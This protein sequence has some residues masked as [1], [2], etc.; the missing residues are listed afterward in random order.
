MKLSAA[1]QLAMLAA[2]GVAVTIGG[3]SVHADGSPIMGEFSDPGKPVFRNGETI[4]TDSPALLLSEADA[5][6]VT[7]DETVIV[8]DGVNYQAYE[9]TP[10]GAGFVE[11]D[12]T[13]DY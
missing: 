9:K 7:K 3:A 1:E 13:R 6:L 12:L 2:L 4:I 10:D 11:L 8:V 5:A